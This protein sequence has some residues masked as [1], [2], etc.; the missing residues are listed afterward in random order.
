VAGFGGE[1]STHRRP[2]N[3]TPA[4]QPIFVSVILD[5]CGHALSDRCA[6]D[7]NLDLASDGADVAGFVAALLGG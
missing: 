6:A 4:D 1:S 7:M 3:V 2:D 5:P